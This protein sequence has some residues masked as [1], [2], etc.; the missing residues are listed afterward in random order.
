MKTSASVNQPDLIGKTISHYKVVSLLGRGAWGTVYKAEDTRLRREVALKF[1]AARPLDGEES[2]RFLQEARAA[3]A[4]SHPSICTVHEIDE[5][6]G[7]TFIAMAHIEGRTLRKVLGDGPLPLGRALEIVDQVACGLAEAHGQGVVHR[8]VKPANIMI[9][10]RGR[11]QIMD[12]GLAKLG[13]GTLATE[14]GAVA[15]TPAYM[16][17]EQARGEATDARCDVWALG[18]LLYELLTGRPA[19]GGERIEAMLYQVCHE[20]P[21]P[22]GDTLSD[23]PREL[24]LILARCLA[25]DPQDRYPSA[26]EFQAAL[27][28]LRR[29]LSGSGGGRLGRLAP[30]PGRRS[31]L[32]TLRV[33]A[34]MLVILVAVLATALAPDF[35]SRIWNRLNPKGGEDSMHVAV[36]PFANLGDAPDNRS[37]CDGLVEILTSKL[38]GLED[39]RG[40]L[41]MIPASELR[42]AGITSGAE[43]RKAF[44]ATL[45]VTGSIQRKSDSLLLTVN[46]VDTRSLRQ[47]DS[48]VLETALA[49]AASLQTS[50]FE[51]VAGMLGISSSPSFGSGEGGAATASSPAYVHYL[52]GRGELTRHDDPARLSAAILSFEKALADDGDYALAEA[53]LGEA[54]WRRYQAG[55]DREHAAEAMGHCLRA[56]KLNPKLPEALV[57]MGIIHRETG[58]ADLALNDFEQALELAP[59]SAR[60]YSEMGQALTDLREFERAEEVYRKGIELRPNDWLMR[61]ELGRF[62]WRRGNY[63]QAEASFREVIDLTPDNASGYSNLGGVYLQ[64][65]R[66]EAA[67][68]MLEKSLAIRPSQEAHSNLGTMAYRDGDYQTAE[69]HYRAAVEIAGH[70]YLLWGQLANCLKHL[71]DREEECVHAYQTAIERGKAQLLLEPR[72]APLLVTLG[73][74]HAILLQR[75]LARGFLN[76]AV[77]IEPENP[78]ILYQAGHSYHLIG[79]RDST[80]ALFERAIRAGYPLHWIRKAP[81]LSRFREDVGYPGFMAEMERELAE[82]RTGK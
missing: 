73:E 71:P 57:T 17:P 78:Q 72:N 38:T 27:G 54:W 22:L 45:A 49:S 20:E 56:L 67:G 46:L 26:V 40:K 21:P 44:G 42:R 37:F 7:F 65:G 76:E 8:D 32:Q 79:E 66:T 55:R 6:G 51:Q 48:A 80:F 75:Q 81:T 58:R 70:R 16:A 63:D 61:N 3:A 13:G 31:R 69:K 4:L 15:G 18:A 25:K 1:L 50:V 36:L 9:T 12:F 53:A 2:A 62:H 47:I 43:A 5:A 59:V 68:E 29:D 74:Y 35:G 23:T 11:V 60:V 28:S 41:R 19:F 14:A 82:S 33:A 10:S 64:L 39:R 77:V 30:P 52:L 34:P 24:E